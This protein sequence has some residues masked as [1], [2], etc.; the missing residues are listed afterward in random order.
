MT[1]EYWIFVLVYWLEYIFGRRIRI[2]LLE[3]V[4]NEFTLQEFTNENIK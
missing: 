4:Q 2:T 3:S 1:N